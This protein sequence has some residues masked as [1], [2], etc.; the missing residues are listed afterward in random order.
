MGYHQRT[1]LSRNL[2][3]FFVSQIFLGIGLVP[4]AAG[5]MNLTS[6]ARKP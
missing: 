5:E 6:L 4:L 3:Y 1:S 2:H